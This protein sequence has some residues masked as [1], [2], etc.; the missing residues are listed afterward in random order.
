[1]GEQVPPVDHGSRDNSTSTGSGPGGAPDA[2]RFK[3]LKFFRRRYLVNPRRQLRAAILVTLVS[4][5]PVV[6]L[7]FTL[8]YVRA[9]EREAIFYKAPVEME[10]RVW[11]SDRQEAYLA[12]AASLVYLVGVFLI[13]VIET[14]QTSGAA[15]GVVRHL[16]MIRDGRYPTRFHLR[17]SDNLTE[18]TEPFNEMAIAL[19]AR[20]LRTAEEL[21]DL[22]A[23]ADAVEG[24]KDVAG[25]LRAMA[26]D[27]ARLA[28]KEEMFE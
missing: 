28:G 11:A 27:Q 18:L 24:G 25:R 4:L 17:D 9:L 10:R 21:Q 3:R 22:A 1:M 20:A 26:A 12:L 19:H 13:T 5:I 7:N 6:I 14:H 2:R 8:G 16:R 23:Q 15:V